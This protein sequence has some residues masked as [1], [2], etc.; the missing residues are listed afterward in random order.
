MNRP[1][2][3]KWA[4]EE[5]GGYSSIMRNALSQSKPENRGLC[6]QGSPA[7]FGPTRCKDEAGCF[8]STRK[9]LASGNPAPRPLDYSFMGLKKVEDVRHFEPMD[10]AGVSSH[11]PVDL[12]ARA[13]GTLCLM[14]R[15]VRPGSGA[16]GKQRQLG[17]DSTALKMANNEIATIVDLRQHL[18]PILNAPWTLTLLDLSNNQLRT[19]GTALQ[20]LPNLSMLYLHGNELSELSELALV[21]HLKQL[22]RFTAHGQTLAGLRHY[23]WH[24][25]SLLPTL[26]QLDLSPVTRQE[27]DRAA[28]WHRDNEKAVA[29]LVERTLQPE[30]VEERRQRARMQRAHEEHLLQQIA[31]ADAAAKKG[32]GK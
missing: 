25:L 10:N 1:A 28:V 29:R 23:R 21:M 32:G 12:V 14:E 22:R 31:A 26:R 2:A 4:H 17:R 24:A 11:Q 6:D 9:L 18:V 20:E 13:S 8:T 16:D 7:R 30:V 5:S 19:V 27:C 3:A 15:T